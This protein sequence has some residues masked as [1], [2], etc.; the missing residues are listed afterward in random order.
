MR[1]SFDLATAIRTVETPEVE[2]LTFGELL[3]GWCAHHT[4]ANDSLRLR[5]WISTFGDRSAWLITS[6]DLAT[7]ALAMKQSGHYKPATINRDLASVGIC[8]PV[9]H[10][11]AHRAARL[12]QPHASASSGSTRPTASGAFSSMPTSSRSCATCPWFTVIA[13]SGCS[14]TC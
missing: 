1:K 4:D 10:R 13:A 12:R 14:S 3:R 8:L 9:G 7:A 2:E 5:K 11:E 6:A